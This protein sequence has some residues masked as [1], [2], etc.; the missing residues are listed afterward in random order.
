MRRCTYALTIIDRALR[1]CYAS[2]VR[3][4][5]T[6]LAATL[7]HAGRTYIAPSLSPLS[8]I[9]PSAIISPWI[10][11]EIALAVRD[12]YIYCTYVKAPCIIDTCLRRAAALAQQR[13]RLRI[14]YRWES[15]DGLVSESRRP[16]VAITWHASLCPRN[17][18]GRLDDFSRTVIIRVSPPDSRFFFYHVQYLIYLSI[19][20]LENLV[21]YRFHLNLYFK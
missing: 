16:Y 6:Q 17:P 21:I 14:L 7:P 11:Q 9:S 20:Y 3:A 4:S 19:N 18:R 12:T 1:M 5:R 8:S 15:T 13:I 2:V 10:F